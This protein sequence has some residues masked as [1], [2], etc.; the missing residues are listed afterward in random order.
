MSTLA[1]LPQTASVPS[2]PMDEFIVQQLIEQGYPADEEHVQK[3]WD[4]YERECLKA[5]ES[6]TWIEGTP[7]FWKK[8]R[9]EA[10]QR[11]E[12]RRKNQ[13]ASIARRAQ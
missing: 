6:D 12:E 4:Y 9:E 8:L 13:G 7:E 1:A 10:H 2:Q 3:V 5:I 11:R